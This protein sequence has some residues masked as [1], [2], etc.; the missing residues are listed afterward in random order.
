MN[1]H[2]FLS[3]QRLFAVIA[4]FTVTI[5]GHADGRIIGTKNYDIPNWFKDSFLDINEDSAEAALAGR[6]LLVFFHLKDCPY[7]AKMLEDSFAD[8][9]ANQIFSRSHFDIVDINIRGAREVTINGNTMT[10]KKYARY[11]NVQYTPTLLFMA[12]NGNTVLEINGYRSPPALRQALE[13][14]HNGAYK[15]MSYN[16]Y[17]VRDTSEPVY[18]LRDDPLFTKNDD[19]S[20]RHHPL[21]VLVEDNNCHG[22][23]WLHDNILNL[24]DVREQMQQLTVARVD[25]LSDAPLITPSGKKTTARQF[26]ADLNLHYRPG[27]V[28]F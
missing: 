22:C 15:T 7:C 25:A 24:V 11:A 8:G 6:H 23:N 4:L 26:A 20:V 1:A 28:F 12:A 27:V 17:R 3:L 19:L 5:G 9:A 13:Y 18:H 16:D 21:M 10:E 14:V 2:N